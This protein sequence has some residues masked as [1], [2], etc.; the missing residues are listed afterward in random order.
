MYPIVFYDFRVNFFAKD[1]SGKTNDGFGR[2]NRR[3]RI[4][5]KERFKNDYYEQR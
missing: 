4:E 5:P 2:F 1:Q 3:T